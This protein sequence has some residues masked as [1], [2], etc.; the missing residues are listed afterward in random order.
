MLPGTHPHIP[1]RTAEVGPTALK[2]RSIRVFCP[3]SGWLGVDPVAIFGVWAAPGGDV[4]KLLVEGGLLRPPVE[5]RSFGAPICH[6]LLRVAGAV[7]GGGP[8]WPR[9]RGVG[10]GRGGAGAVSVGG[11]AGGSAGGVGR[12]KTSGEPRAPRLDDLAARLAEFT[13]TVT[14]QAGKTTTSRY[15]VLTTLLGHDAYPASR[16]RAIFGC[17]V[18]GRLELTYK[19]VKSTLRGSGRPLRGQSPDLA[20]QEIWGSARHLQRPSR[21]DGQR[22]RIK[23]T[24]S[25][26]I[27]PLL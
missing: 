10:V 16:R 2:M 9:C 17:T 15:R 24:Q 20:E 23:S 25:G 7:A 21:P 11:H 13:V 19:S 1:G 22:H 4:A 12:R 8:D 26:L 5:T 3:D 18:S 6:A 27:R 14:D